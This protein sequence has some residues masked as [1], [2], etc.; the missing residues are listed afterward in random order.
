MGAKKTSMSSLASEPRQAD[1]KVGWGGMIQPWSIAL[2]KTLPKFIQN[3]MVQVEMGEMRFTVVESELLLAEMVKNEVQARKVAGRYG[4]KFAAVTHFFGYQGRSSMPSVFDARLGY[5]YGHLASVCIESGLT[6]HC[7]T[8]RGLVSGPEDWKLG[9]IPFNSLLQI[10]PAQQDV[11]PDLKSRIKDHLPVMPAAEVRPTCKAYRWMKT[12][13]EQWQNSDRFCN[14]GP[15]QF[16]GISAD[17]HNR[18][19][20]EE[21]AEYF[22][23][24]RHVEMFSTI[25]RETCSFGVDEE[26]LK[27]TFASLHSLLSL[28]FH[29][30]DLLGALP[31]P[32]SVDDFETAQQHKG[33]RPDLTKLDRDGKSKQSN[34][35]ANGVSISVTRLPSVR[36]MAFGQSGWGGAEA[37]SEAYPITP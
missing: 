9:A 24:L 17:F 12:A 1:A 14:P 7:C 22:K 32:I 2:F 30:S 28:R 6:G 10:I 5:A 13:V 34:Q 18:L 16:K 3:D 33:S 8:I 37:G 15:V 26:F 35:R 21:Q 19:L 4:G 11:H 23:M 27:V 36:G 25:V 20:H 29:S 31:P